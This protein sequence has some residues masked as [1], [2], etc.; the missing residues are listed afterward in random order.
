VQVRGQPFAAENARASA[1]HS[2]GC[3]RAGRCR[4]RLTG[5]RCHLGPGLVSRVRRAR[6]PAQLTMITWGAPVR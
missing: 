2:A 3:G 4:G 5:I 6:S 1:E